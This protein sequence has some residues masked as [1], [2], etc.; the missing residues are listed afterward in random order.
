M[1]FKRVGKPV[2]GRPAATICAPSEPATLPLNFL[3]VVSGIP[4]VTLLGGM[5]WMIVLCHR[6]G[7]LIPPLSWVIVLGSLLM[8]G[9]LGVGYVRRNRSASYRQKADDDVQHYTVPPVEHQSASR[10]GVGSPEQSTQLNEI[11]YA[12]FLATL[13]AVILRQSTFAIRTLGGSFC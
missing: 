1:L 5:A 13:A 8:I 3:F 12:I 11:P 6:R 2:A 7:Q 9:A 10:D 4:A